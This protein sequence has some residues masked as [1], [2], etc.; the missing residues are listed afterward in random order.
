MERKLSKSTCLTYM[1]TG[2]LLQSLVGKKSL[3]GYTHI[4]VDEVHERDEDTDLLLMVVRKF[5]QKARMPVK[6]I[7]M[8]A[9]A[10]TKKFSEYFHKPTVDGSIDAPVV[11]VKVAEPFAV[12]VYHLDDLVKHEVCTNYYISKY[13]INIFQNMILKYQTF[14]NN[15]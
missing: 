6:V 2:C 15:C 1:T 4:I 3:D 9:T 10:D 5:M 14:R 8:S 12:R 7:L 11:E 13:I